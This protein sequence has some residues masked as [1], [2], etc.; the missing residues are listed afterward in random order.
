MVLGALKRLGGAAAIENAR[1]SAGHRST[2]GPTI[3]PVA[4]SLNLHRNAIELTRKD[5]AKAN[6]FVELRGLVGRRASIM[7]RC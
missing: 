1:S 5:S 3:N 4:T 2:G 6:S 7:P